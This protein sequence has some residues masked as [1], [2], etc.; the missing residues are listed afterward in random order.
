[1]RTQWDA[2]NHEAW[3]ERNVGHARYPFERHLRC[4]LQSR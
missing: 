4:A 2:A 3:N 1:L